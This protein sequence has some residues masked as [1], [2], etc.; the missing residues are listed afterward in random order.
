[1]ILQVILRMAEFPMILRNAEF[2]M[3]LFNDS[4]SMIQFLQVHSFLGNLMKGATGKK[5][6]GGNQL[7]KAAAPRATS[8]L[9]RSQILGFKPACDE[10]CK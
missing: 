5:R 10:A 6:P 4:L 2:S 8:A 1:M 3:I 9:V 7:Y